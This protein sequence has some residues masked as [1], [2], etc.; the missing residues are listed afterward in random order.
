MTAKPYI[1]SWTTIE[2]AG[3]PVKSGD[4][5]GWNE[6]AADVGVHRNTIR[7]WVKVGIFP[8]PRKVG[9]RVCLWSTELIHQWRTGNAETVEA[10]HVAGQ[11][12]RPKKT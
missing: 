9:P 1:A 11:Q 3:R 5:K 12:R 8:A 10:A 7:K 4:F 6:V 2:H